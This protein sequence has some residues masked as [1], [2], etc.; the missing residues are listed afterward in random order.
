MTFV[1]ATGKDK[2]EVHFISN[3]APL[4]PSGVY[5]GHYLV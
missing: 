4:V 5:L 3:Y 2:A 1:N